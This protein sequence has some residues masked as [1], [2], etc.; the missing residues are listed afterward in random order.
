MAHKTPRSGDFSRVRFLVDAP[1]LFR[2]QARGRGG[3]YFRVDGRGSLFE[4][5]R[6]V[7]YV[8]LMGWTPP[9]TA[10]MCQS[11]G[12][13]HHFREASMGKV[14]TIDW[15]WRRMFFRHMARMR[16]AP[17]NSARNCGARKCWN[18]SRFSR[19]APWPWRPAQARIS[20]G[21]RSASSAIQCG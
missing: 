8:A 2:L 16:L 9:P 4:A 17:S 19:R 10:S 7:V 12:V 1:D 15:I 6:P 13:E 20:G 18:C 3:E 21:A 11:G 5:L 14:S